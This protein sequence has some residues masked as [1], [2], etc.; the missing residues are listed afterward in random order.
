MIFFSMPDDCPVVPLPG[1]R[2]F[3]FLHKAAMSWH[4]FVHV[5]KKKKKYVIS[6]S[7]T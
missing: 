7:K 3:I 1:H 2:Y 4:G 6:S 5:S